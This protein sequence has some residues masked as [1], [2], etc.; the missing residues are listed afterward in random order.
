MTDIP[1]AAAA[2]D[3][4][5]LDRDA[6]QHWIVA[7]RWFGSKSREVS[8]IDI[9]EVVPLRTEPPLLVLALVEAR[10]G[11]GT[12]ETYQVPLGLRPAE[13]GWTERVIVEA[14]GWTVYDALADA[15]QGRELLHRIR[16]G[17]R[18][19]GRGRRAALPVGGERRRGRRRQRRGPPR[20]RRAVR[21]P[22][23]SSASR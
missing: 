2:G 13:D 12:H 16:Q 11:E 1:A 3:L 4:A 15:A 21:T 9:A 8:Q 18:V 19:P 6:L 10:F 22:R 20:R 7:Q 17:D 23:S 14:D 5:F